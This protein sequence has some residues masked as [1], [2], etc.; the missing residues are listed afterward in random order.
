M[1]EATRKKYE[2][3][4]QLYL[5]EQYSLVQISRILK[6]NRGKFTKF[7]KEKNIEVIN[8]QNQ[9]E[10]HS[11]IFNCIDTEEKAYWLGF[12]YADGYVSNTNN[13]IELALQCNDYKHIEKFKEFLHSQNAITYYK[14]RVRITFRNKVIKQDL[15]KLGCVPNKSLILTFPTNQQVSSHLMKH[16]VRGFIDGDGYI[17]ITSKRKGRLAICSGSYSF[18]KELVRTMQWKENKILKD[19]RSSTYSISWGGR[20]AF[21]ILFELYEEAHVYLER[22]HLKYCEIK[23]AVLG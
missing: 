12:L 4:E 1:L 7:L 14:N 9:S 2:I 13:L 6:I 18:L 21:N 15:I 23:N 22:K 16:F 11:N 3:G 19:K 17:G 5:N 20:V 10:I 8:K